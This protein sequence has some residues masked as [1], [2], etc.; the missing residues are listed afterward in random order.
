MTIK[1]KKHWSDQSEVARDELRDAV[2]QTVDWLI[3]HRR[4][5]SYAAGGILGAALLTGLVAYSRHA[6][7]TESWDKLSLAEMYAYAG[8]PIEA[9][10]ALAQVSEAG[11]GS[12]AAAA[13]ARMLEGD[14]LIAGQKYADAATS[15]G[16]A[17]EIAPEG[18]RPFALAEK[19]MTLEEEGKMAECAAAAQSFLDT[20]ADHLLAA[21]VHS[22]LAR[23]QMAQG[24]ADAAKS[25]LQRISLQYPNS[26]W[27]EW[28]TT[29]L[30]ASTPK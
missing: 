1:D 21:Q 9:Q 3:E 26:P 2:E 23:C 14:I 18:I 10:S 29:R 15:Y 4:E 17:A 12:A 8:H 25:T 16:K 5:A 30:Q 27:A 6:K 28:A 19:V 22:I 24:Q 11:G 20:N 7:M 13:L